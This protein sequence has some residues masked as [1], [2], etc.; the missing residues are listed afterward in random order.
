MKRRFV[1]VKTSRICACVLALLVGGCSADL[2]MFKADWNWWSKSDKPQQQVQ[3]VGA[4]AFVSPDGACAAV[5]TGEGVHAVSLGM[6]ECQLVQLAGQT[7]MIDIGTNERGERT[8]VITYPEGERA[9]TYRFTSGTL[10]SIEAP[11]PS[12]KPAKQS[13]RK[14]KPKASPPPS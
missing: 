4:E 7:S 2:A 6:T 8:A 14:R 1:P 9:G 13:P 10:V 12:A 5:A 3:V 11:P